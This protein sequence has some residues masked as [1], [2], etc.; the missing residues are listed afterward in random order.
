MDR[1]LHRSVLSSAERLVTWAPT[2]GSVPVNGGARFT[3]W[4]PRATDIDV[5]FDH[6]GFTVTRAL[7][8]LP[9]GTFTGW[10][11][12]LREGARYRLRVDGGPARPD[13][14]SRYQ[15]EGVHGSS[16]FVDPTTFV[17]TDN[18][19]RGV[20]RDDLVIYE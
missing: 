16:A 11:P 5:V 15:P 17:W 12:D 2:L 7:N 8:R 13:P 3:V 10:E 9:D 18:S 1:A 19:W 6:G 14:A 4:A 20:S